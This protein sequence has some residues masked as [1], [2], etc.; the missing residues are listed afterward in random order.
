MN[1]LLKVCLQDT[2]QDRDSRQFLCSLRSGFNLFFI[3]YD[4]AET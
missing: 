4:T 2:S 3:L 1:G